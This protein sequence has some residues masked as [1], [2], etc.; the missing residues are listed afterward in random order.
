MVWF[1]SSKLSKSNTQAPPF[2]EISL[3]KRLKPE[4]YLT[5]MHPSSPPPPLSTQAFYVLLALSGNELHGYAIKGAVYNCSLGSINLTNSR[6]YAL[7]GRLHDE[8]LIE[9]SGRY[10]AKK[11]GKERLHYTI[12]P[13]GSI[14]LQEELLRQARAV[15][16][17]R[18]IGLLDNKTPT[19]I[20]RLVL[21][22]GLE[23]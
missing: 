20:Q 22:A 23:A 10:P 2:P 7:I 18:N 9:L 13:H 14:R 5:R 8:A 15:K 17:A 12:S 3:Q 21:N 4:L 19:D 6:L 16:I 1:G 11:S